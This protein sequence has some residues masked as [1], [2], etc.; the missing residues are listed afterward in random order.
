MKVSYSLKVS[1]PAPFSEQ[2]VKYLEHT[3]DMETAY[4]FKP[5]L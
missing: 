1:Q 5:L 2:L 3:Y 4:G